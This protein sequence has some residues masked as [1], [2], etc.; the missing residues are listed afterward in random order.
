MPIT[1]TD[2]VNTVKRS[3]GK[4]GRCMAERRNAAAKEPGTVARKKS[5][6]NAAPSPSEAPLAAI[7]AGSQLAKTVEIVAWSAKMKPRRQGNGRRALIVIDSLDAR[8]VAGETC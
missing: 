4:P 3:A 2:A 8:F 1:T 5:A 6:T 7:A